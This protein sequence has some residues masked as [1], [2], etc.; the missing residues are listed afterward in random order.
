MAQIQTPILPYHNS[1][2]I[3][4]AR[5]TTAVTSTSAQEK[6]NQAQAA[7]EVASSCSSSSTTS[8]CSPLNAPPGYP[9][10]A[11]LM[12]LIPETSIFRRFGTLNSL[13]LLY[14]QA[15]LTDI[16]RKLRVAQVT[17]FNK[18]EGFKH[19]YGKNWYFLGASAQDGDEAQLELVELAR[20]KLDRYNAA[21][22]QQEKVLSFSPPGVYDMDFIQRFLASDEMGEPYPLTGRDCLTWGM[23]THANPKIQPANDL[24]ALKPRRNADGFSNWVTGT[25]INKFFALGCARFRKPSDRHGR[26]GFEDSAIHRVTYSITSVLASLL[27]IAS[28]AVLYAV[29]SMKLRLVLIAVFN[30]LLTVCLT[31]FTT[32]KRTDVFAVAA[33]FS[34]VQVVFVQ[35]GD[36][37]GIGATGRN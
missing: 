7:A 11:E 22:I 35:G 18:G 13:N 17:D 16:E 1:S 12:N 24:V 26:V 19:L 32:A 20:E 23:H 6:E 5:P 30:V 9:K 29:H 31:T 21:L 28:I 37:D 33:A 15:E 34:A 27:P 4:I 14:L 3:S 8:T 10:L 2:R 36:S 25:G